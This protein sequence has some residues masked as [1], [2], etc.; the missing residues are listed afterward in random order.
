MK[1][2]VRFG[3]IGLGLMGREFASAVAR[4][5]HLLDSS[6]QPQI[7]GVCDQSVAGFEWF[8]RNFPGIKVFTS[9]YKD[10]LAN[11][12]IDAIYCAVPHNLHE[13]MYID[14]IR[15]G[16]HLLGEKPF[17][18]DQK[19]NT[20][21]LAAISENPEVVV[22]CSSEFP[23]FPGCRRLLS[24]L[25]DQEFGQILE[26]KAGF[27]H[28]S[29]LDLTKPI[30]WK[31]Q[32][33]Y[34]GEYGCMGDLGM[35]ALHVPLRMGWVPET[36]YALLSKHVDLRPDGKGGSVACETWDNATLA[37]RVKGEDGHAFPMILE[38]K[39]MAPGMTNS[40][41]LEVSGLKGAAR[42][43]TDDPQAFHYLESNG[44]EQAWC[45]I[46][47]GSK[48][49]FPTITGSIFEFGFSDAILQMWAT[50]IEDIVVGGRSDVFDCVT[51]EETRL[52]HALL[53][54]ALMSN[55]SGRAEVV[56]T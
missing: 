45:R 10:L 53:T 41:Y 37:C 19:A 29:D 14:I 55:K 8:R 25:S 28:S 49:Q 15:S 1:K 36:V 56:C 7:V 46:G 26:V 30:N 48:P 33:A 39:R 4:W 27:C 24:W 42:F 11:P 52:S 44:Q 32:I 51:P 9:D 6:A 21:I 38:M 3:V 43:S 5:C 50:F 18:I 34:N 47:V 23:F 2:I 16:K 13:K 31:R 22:R 54:A 35:H 17:G 12:Q 20:A 40:W